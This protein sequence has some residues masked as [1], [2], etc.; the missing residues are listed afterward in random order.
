MRLVLV[1]GVGKD[2]VLGDHRGGGGHK[3]F[4][5]DMER[6]NQL[7]LYRSALTLTVQHSRLG[8]S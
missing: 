5:A 4:R 8:A 6:A 1:A 3:T 2:G 7:A